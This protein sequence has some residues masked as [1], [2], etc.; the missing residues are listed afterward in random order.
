MIM[1]AVG[2]PA[3]SDGTASNA[4]AVQRPRAT[5]APA[6]LAPTVTP[7][8]ELL[9]GVTGIGE[10]KAE[11]DA[12]LVFMVSGMVAEVNVKEGEFV[13]KGQLLASLDTRTFDQQLR[14]AEAA[15]ASAKAQEAAF[16]EPPRAADAKVARAAVQQAQA[17]LNQVLAGPKAQDRQS[18]Q[19]GLTAAQASLQSTRDRLSLAKTQ[20]EAQVQQVAQVLT[21]AQARY[22]QAK[23]NWEYAKETGNDPIVPRV[24]DPT[25]GMQK[26]NKL[27]DG[28]LENYYAQFVQAEAALHQAERIGDERGL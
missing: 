1:L 13:T 23:Y 25:T 8:M 6:T 20:A 2:L 24:L 7:V 14:Q 9:Q 27:S 21:Q 3:C 15:A 12:D 5:A 10:V 28:Q 19:A 18:A 16:D 26:D 22:A 17:M 11:R 4:S